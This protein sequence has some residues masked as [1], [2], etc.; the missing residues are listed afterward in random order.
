MI[1]STES[2][3]IV[4][5]ERNSE[6]ETKE[7]IISESEDVFSEIEDEER[8]MKKCSNLLVLRFDCSRVKYT[9]RISKINRTG[10]SGLITRAISAY[11][12]LG[13]DARLYAWDRQRIFVCF[14]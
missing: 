7:T 1:Q 5:S 8:K 11:S 10:S 4:S 12:E 2:Y 9:S 14:R 13:L 3:E 6:S